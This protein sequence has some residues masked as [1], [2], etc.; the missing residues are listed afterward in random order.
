[1][2]LPDATPRSLGELSRFLVAAYNR[3]LEDHCLQ[4]AGSL[5]FTTL[6]ALVPL[7][8]VALALVTAF[9]VFGAF[10]NGVDEWLAE[11]V[12]PEQIATAVTRYLAEF[13]GAAARLTAV[14]IV[15]LA[16][17]AL[18]TM[19]T[20]DRAFNQIFRVGR[21]RPVAQRLLTYW[22]VLTLGPILIGLSVSITSYLVSASLGFAKGV[23]GAGRLLLGVVPVLLTSVA[24]TLLYIWVPNRRVRARHALVGGIVAGVLFELMT[25]G[26]GF[27]ISRF[28]T[29]T[30]IYG[31]FAAVPM[32]LLWMY[33]SWV[34]VLLGG[35]VT[36]LVPGY[37]FG[38]RRRGLGAGQHFY[39]VLALLGELVKAQRAGEVRPLARLAHDLR[40]LPE[41]CER[42]LDR[43]AGAGWAAAAGG[44]AW[45]LV[46]DAGSLSV[47]DVYRLFVLDARAGDESLEAM[48]AAHQEDVGRRMQV[49]LSELFAEM[50]KT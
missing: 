7:V 49:R 15:F 30:A 13:S 28:P 16:F 45:V 5:T 18:M 33:L 9:P 2:Q 50:E 38:D 1:M 10:T 36:A 4:V 37:R 3:M 24:F 34:V 41:Q 21:E 19:L 26:F 17:T 47:A 11:N 25:R 27:Y 40:L 42:L 8:T 46:R 23:P 31:A 44:D 14:G 29:Y 32:F 20:I 43:L 6:L 12:L 48:I 22:A 39:D 35:T